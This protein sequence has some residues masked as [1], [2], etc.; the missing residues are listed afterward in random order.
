MQDTQDILHSGHTLVFIKSHIEQLIMISGVGH[1]LL[2]V[3]VS[4]LKLLLFSFVK[5]V[6]PSPATNTEWPLLPLRA[7]AE[8]LATGIRHQA[9][10]QCSTSANPSLPSFSAAASTFHVRSPSDCQKLAVS[11]TVQG[12]V[13]FPSCF[14]LYLGYYY[15]TSSG[16]SRFHL[17]RDSIPGVTGFH[18]LWGPGF[19]CYGGP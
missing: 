18:M 10:Q 2:L 12:P 16:K 11:V 7:S 14:F 13:A 9:L 6:Q 3:K 5:P 4:K 15:C 1:S 17:D 8:G 19:T